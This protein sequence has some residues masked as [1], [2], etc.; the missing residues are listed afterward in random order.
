[1]GKPLRILLVEDN[2]DDAALVERALRDGG[3]D[4]ILRRVETAEEMRTALHEGGWDAV[5]ADYN[6]PRFNAIEALEVLRTSRRDL[7]F[8]IVSGGIGEE[9]ATAA[10]KAGAHDYVMKDNLKRLVPAIE[11][12]I[13]DAMDRLLARRAGEALRESEARYRVL[14]QHAPDAIVLYED[15]TGRFIEANPQAERLFGL[16]G[17]ELVKIGP[18]AVSPERQPDG[19]PSEMLARKYIDQAVRGDHVRFEWMHRHADGAEIP[20]EVGLTAFRV[21]PRM[22]V[23]GIV[24]DITGRK[25]AE[26]VVA[27]SREELRVRVEQLQRANVEIETFL[28]TVSHDLKAPLVTLHGMIALLL[29]RAGGKLA[30]EERH[31]IQRMRANVDH[32][33]RLVEDLLDMAR[34]GRTQDHVEEFDVSEAVRAAVEQ[35]AGRIESAGLSLGLPERLGRTRYDRR[36]LLRVFA[37]L[38]SNAM[39]YAAPGRRPEVEISSGPDGQMLLVRVKDNG[40]GIEER[41]YERIFRLFERVDPASDDGT[42]VGLSIVKRIVELYGGE[43]RVESQPGAGSTFSFTVPRAG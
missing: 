26:A 30:D 14:F 39:Q 36:R 20:C 31:Y 15:E 27:A 9:E 28:Y 21:G 29:D 17:A 2:R 32:M 38:L 1:M 16:P 12:E 11:R 22:V 23:Q 37:N 13:R 33:Q 19:S 10:M 8:I 5:V 4:P 34:L 18:V 3:Y 25:A 24:R 43:I 42:G 40:M 41:H 7:P 35:L 6:L